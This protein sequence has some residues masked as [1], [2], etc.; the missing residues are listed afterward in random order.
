M[1]NGVEGYDGQPSNKIDTKGEWPKQAGTLFKGFGDDNWLNRQ[2]NGGTYLANYF[3]EKLNAAELMGKGFSTPRIAKM[4]DGAISMFYSNCLGEAGFSLF[5]PRL[6][7]AGSIANFNPSSTRP[8]AT[9]GSCRT[10]VPICMASPALHSLNSAT[11]G[12]VGLATASSSSSH[13][14]LMVV[15]LPL[16]SQ[17]GC[18]V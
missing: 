15:A 17:K 14:M 16:T 18:T 10:A 12:K 9:L 2:D 3:P 8:L 6:G 5:N 7:I 1:W 4:K 11:A 13:L